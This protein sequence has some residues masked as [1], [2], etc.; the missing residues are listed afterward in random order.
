MAGTIFSQK[1]NVDN[2]RWPDMKLIYGWLQIN[3]KNAQISQKK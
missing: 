1:G 3:K 2:I